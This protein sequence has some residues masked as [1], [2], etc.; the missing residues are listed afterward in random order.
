MLDMLVFIIF[1]LFGSQA[2]FRLASSRMKIV[3]RI[4]TRNENPFFC[5][6]IDA[7]AFRFIL[8]TA[9]TFS[10]RF[11]HECNLFYQKRKKFCKKRIFFVTNKRKYFTYE[12]NVFTNEKYFVKGEFYLSILKQI[13]LCVKKIVNNEII[14]FR[15]KIVFFKNETDLTIYKWIQNKHIIPVYVPCY[16]WAKRT[17]FLLAVIYGSPRRHSDSSKTFKKNR[18]NVR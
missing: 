12:I 10:R 15:S 5:A 8:K 2:W 1:C 18:K 17:K 9:C 14:I 11:C 13:L 4:K 7:N 6:G 16:E 3:N